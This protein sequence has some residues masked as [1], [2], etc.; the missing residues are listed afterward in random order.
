MK[1]TEITGK[2]YWR[3]LDQLAET[4]EFKKFI[5]SEFPENASEMKSPVT[6]RKFLALMG[7]SI[8][9]AGL[10]GCRRPVET[11]VPYVS[12][13]ENVIPGI[14]R[15]YAT[16]MPFG[17]HSYGLL[18]ET[19]EGRP[20][21]IEGN[22]LHPSSLG[23]TNARMQA[24]ILRLY[25]PD[26]SKKVL[27]KGADRTWADFVEFWRERYP[28]FLESGG[29][30]LAVLTGSYAAPTMNR[31][32]RTFRKTFPKALVSVYDSVNDE[33]LYN[34]I[35]IASGKK[36]QPVYH[37]EKAKTILTLDA[38]IFL[39]ENED[40]TA[41]KGF[42]EGRRLETEKD[43]MNRLYAVESGFSI[44]GA[45]ADHRLKMPSSHIPAVA[46]VL[47]EALIDRGLDLNVPAEMP[48]NPTG[49]ADVKWVN[50]LADELITNRGNSL[51]VGGRTQ[52]SA[53]HAL[54]F[55][56]N[57]ALGNTG[58]TVEYYAAEGGESSSLA[59]LAALKD[60]IQAGKVNTLF[61][62]D[63]NP[64]YTTPSDFDFSTLLGKVEHTIQLSEY[65]DEST[66]YAEWHLPEA[67]FLESWGDACSVNGTKSVIQPMI[68]P[69]FGG[70]T[71][72]E[73]LA[74][75]VSGLEKRS[76]DVIRET[77]QDLLESSDFETEWQM[78]LHDGAWKSSQGKASRIDLSV[79][80]I[81]DAWNASV[82]NME[83]LS[84][85]NL[86]IVFHPSPA[87]YDGRY[88]NNGWMQ[89]LPDPVTKIAWDNAA[90]ISPATAEALEVKQGDVV[91]L[92]LNG[93]SIAIP[94]HILP[95]QAD[96]SVGL[97]LGY[98][99]KKMGKIA[100]GVGVDVNP[101]RTS[102]SMNY[103]TGGTIRKTGKKHLLANTQD[104]NSMEDR[105]LIREATLSEYR[106]HPEFAKEMVEHP[107]LVSL[108]DE[109]S[110]D[111][112]YQWGMAIDLTSCS[113]CNACVIACQSENNIPIVGKEQVAE[114]REM[115]WIRLDRYFDGEV[116]DPKMIFQPVACQH[117]ENAPCEQVCPVQA[118]VHDSEGLNVMTYNRCIGTRYCSNNCPYKV[119]RFNF[120][121]YT[122]ALAETVKM[123]QNPDVTVRSRGVMEKCTFCTQRI[124][125]AKIAAKLED[126]ELR[127][128]EVVT[129][130]Q[131]AC[132]ADAIVFGNINDPE[133]TV[134]K[135]K[136]RNRDYT[137]LGELNLKTRNT[138]LAKIRNPNPDIE[139]LSGVS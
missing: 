31:L 5:D 135:I 24:E 83:S 102:A 6:R 86:E 124:N 44:T 131:Q 68:E 103:A 12:A 111:E 93:Q 26:R 84:A 14:S 38:D 91:T 106:K 45:M 7:A 133:S 64:V 79:S 46:A 96:Y 3:S 47:A 98:G 137:M 48:E 55:A 94:V 87:L 95:G 9:F 62:L 10:A 80:K 50:A 2:E 128:G 20:T 67:H 90:L 78:V 65:V 58:N 130:C 81:R 115:H 37:Y 51:I 17:F 77:W 101:L 36:Y 136:S 109:H 34:G 73:V 88:A 60:A 99:R 121:N 25:D 134:S 132:P 70:Q 71:K 29:E 127:D 11:I 114:G 27:F 139:A 122:N 16:T 72:S 118:T 39:S 42:A 18:V 59:S 100:E 56:M 89:E 129:A 76:Y 63:S 126:R 22:T 28:D 69:L 15:H 35:R 75:I 82:M 110:Y 4:P 52:P 85:E 92:G 33:N 125:K 53:V 105:P 97:T 1:N 49:E 23:K 123:A 30:G 21:K 8:A 43:E 119:R 113:G 107:P 138:F 40:V 54:I 116:D 19:H 61:L 108:W 41:N 117:C 57:H 13:P 112:G 104:H 74:M 32:L 66:A 120:F